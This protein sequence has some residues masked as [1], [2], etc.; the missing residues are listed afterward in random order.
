M[1]RTFL[2]LESLVSQLEGDFL[3]E[4]DLDLIVIHE[5]KDFMEKRVDEGRTSA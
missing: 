2:P 4:S 3:E 1:V 5:S